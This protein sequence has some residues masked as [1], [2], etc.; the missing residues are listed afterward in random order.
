MFRRTILFFVMLSCML[1][2]EALLAAPPTSTKIVISQRYRFPNFGLSWPARVTVNGPGF[3][4]IYNEQGGFNVTV[5][6]LGR[7]VITGEYRSPEGKTLKETI[8]IT[9]NKL[10]GQQAVTLLYV[11]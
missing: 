6:R 9:I 1:P 8:S 5:D 10:G 3:Y 7:Y 4:R 2:V 11:P